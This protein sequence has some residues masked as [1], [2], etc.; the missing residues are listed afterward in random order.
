MSIMLKEVHEG[1]LRR[2]R[3]RARFV[4]GILIALLVASFVL[5]WT[6]RLKVDLIRGGYQIVKCHLKEAQG[7]RALLEVLRNRPLTVGQ[8]LSIA[9]VVI[10]ESKTSKIPVHMILGIMDLESGFKSEAVSSE[11]ARGLMQIMPE[12][13]KEYVSSVDLQTSNARHD[14]ALNVRVGIRYLGDLAQQ[15]DGNW[16]KVLK[17]YG[18]HVKTSPDGYIRAVMA[19]ASKYKAQLE[20]KDF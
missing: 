4:H 15:H 20:E 17:K 18:G 14:P 1:T 2:I 12:K 13:W 8:A 16:E 11:G 7:R 5:Q 10:D 19:R 9:D 6:E 3:R